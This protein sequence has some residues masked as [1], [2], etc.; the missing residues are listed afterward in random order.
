MLSRMSGFFLTMAF[1]TLLLS[2]FPRPFSWSSRLS[3]ILPALLAF[4]RLPRLL[5]SRSFG[6][7]HT[8]LARCLLRLT[9]HLNH[10]PQPRL[11][12][13]TPRHWNFRPL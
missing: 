12:P 9:F 7:S 5:N 4:C 1:T 2:S 10:F 8:F 13:T 3:A 6:Y 11:P